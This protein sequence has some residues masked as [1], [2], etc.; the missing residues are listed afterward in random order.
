[1]KVLRAGLG[2]EGNHLDVT[3][4]TL[5]FDAD[6]TE[7]D[8]LA[9]KQAVDASDWEVALAKYGAWGTLL[10]GFPE[11]MIE[12][13]EH[14]EQR[15]SGLERDYLRAMVNAAVEA[16]TVGQYDKAKGWAQTV[17]S[18]RPAD[19]A[20]SRA[21]M[22]AYGG[23]NAYRNVEGEYRRLRKALDTVADGPED[24]TEDCYRRL[25][26][27]KAAYE[28][29]VQTAREANSDPDT[30]HNIP[31]LPGLLVGREDD[32]QEVLRRVRSADGRL[33]TLCG[34][35]GVGKTW[36]ALRAADSIKAYFLQGAWFVDLSPLEP[37]PD[38]GIHSL[39]ASA[40]GLEEK[41]YGAV[42]EALENSDRLLLLDNC[43]HVR[44][45]C[46]DFVKAL[47]AHCSRLRIL[48]TSQQPL[49]LSNESVVRVRPLG[50]SAAVS[51][52]GSPPTSEK[53]MQE[54]PAVRL[55][56]EQIQ[57]KDRDFDLVPENAGAV[58]RICEQLGGN[59]L[60][61]MMAAVATRAMNVHDLASKLEEDGRFSLL[62]DGDGDER[63][64]H[65]TLQA[66][67]D[68]SY[69]LLDE[70][71]PERELLTRLSVFV[72]GWSLR[73]A[74]TVSTLPGGRTA[75]A[76]SSLV[77]KSWVTY[78]RQADRYSFLDTARI[79]ART[80]LT[81][82]EEALR[83]RR[84]HLGWLLSLTRDA[85]DDRYRPLG[86]ANRLSQRAWMDI[87]ENEHANLRAA[88][89]WSLGC[90]DG[91]VVNEGLRL[92]VAL[93]PFWNV[94]NYWDEA[95]AYL[96]KFI[97]RVDAVT[98]DVAPPAET[99]AGAYNHAGLFAVHHGR[100]QEA[101]SLLLHGWRLA[102]GVGPCQEADVLVNLGYLASKPSSTGTPPEA[103]AAH[104]LEMYDRASKQ[105]GLRDRAELGSFWAFFGLGWDCYEGRDWPAARTHFRM[106]RKVACKYD[107]EILEGHA[108]QM[109][110]RTALEEDL[111]DEA[112]GYACDSLRLRQRVKDLGSIASCLE[113]LSGMAMNQG[114]WRSAVVLGAIAWRSRKDA[115]I[116]KQTEAECREGLLSGISAEVSTEKAYEWWRFGASRTREQLLQYD[117]AEDSPAY[118]PQKVG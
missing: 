109:L 20:A 7:V 23:Q 39:V 50:T 47:R 31:A 42:L 75:W 3:P 46:R 10:E 84:T 69:E 79:Y 59:P 89:D 66:L 22:E 78:H 25:M 106:A 28:T 5:C 41:T 90:P 4:Q 44:A 9:F 113:T 83:L 114:Y 1:M 115:G 8:V 99:L 82:P 86:T 17:T 70:G 118:L 58:V 95:A 37:S 6:G 60:A 57:L 45:P 15:R 104:V 72:G 32:V 77:D 11:E 105:P 21:L 101:L 96:D 40:L 67:M 38:A 51:V 100:Y 103:K 62:V 85:E 30:P 97:S 73:A 110:A 65:Q 12:G 27:A 61:L 35:G 74:E 93:G 76:L 52:D 88:L 68:W 71:G 80:R 55:L 87:L 24:E 13:F 33:V 14:I 112:F 98:G 63:A 34:P 48:A 107:D 16:A 19:Q 36:L 117:P 94:R 111:A 81:D 91:A 43:E 49:N 102:Q 92:A 116:A 108:L 53:L 29:A 2:D 54:A 56:V 18:L 64:H 26:R